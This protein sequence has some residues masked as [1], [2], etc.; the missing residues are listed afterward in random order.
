M[1]SMRIF[2]FS[3]P[4]PPL[5]IYVQNSS[6]PFTLDVQFQTP[7][8]SYDNQLIKRKHNPRMI[9]MLSGPSF[10]SA[11]V[12]SINSL[13][14]FGFPLTS[15]HFA[16]G[17]LFAFSWLNTLVCAVVQKYHEISFIYNL[18]FFFKHF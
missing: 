7:H 12:F 17:S 4:P 1:T 13:I 5:S 18:F 10:G 9:I 11:L 16:E 3:R 8:P 15:F 14:L 2:Q 6:S